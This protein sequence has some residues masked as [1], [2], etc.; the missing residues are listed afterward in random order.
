MLN[1]SMVAT[2]D[3]GK[4][5]PVAEA[6]TFMKRFLGLMGRKE[7]YYGLLLDP[8]N[9]VHTCFMRFNLDVLFLDRDNRIVAIRHAMKPWR[10]TSI[11]KNAHKVLE[12][13]SSLGFLRDLK[14]GSK[15]MIE[16]P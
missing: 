3:E 1:V 12:Y 14:P 8:C 5:L 4:Q 13:P 10:A 16:M 9:S 7:S 2:S 6:N 15:I 11:V